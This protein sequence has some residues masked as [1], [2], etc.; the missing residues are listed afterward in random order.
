MLYETPARYI[1]SGVSCLAILVYD[2]GQVSQGLEM[3]IQKKCIT[4]VV[5]VFSGIVLALTVSAH[6]NAVD[7]V[8]IG[9]AG[10]GL[11]TMKLLG[12]A[13]EK[14]HPGFR[15]QV[16]PSL[17]SAGGI[18]ALAKKSLDIVTSSRPLR[19]EE[20]S[21]GL[22]EAAYARTPFVF[23]THAD[24]A[25]DGVTLGELEDIYIGKTV[26]WPG[27]TR[28]RL[29]L[30]PETDT[31]AGLLRSLS[32]VI[33]RA[34]K[35]AE[36]NKSKILAITDQ[37]CAETVAR[38]PG[39]FGALTLTQVVTEN[40]PLKILDF[41]GVTPSVAALSDGTYKLYK[42]LYLIT[43]ASSRP[44]VQ[45]FAEFVHSAEGR[46]IVAKSGN[47]A[48]VEPKRKIMESGK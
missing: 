45:R 13:F 5:S 8:R 10:A 24:V 18:T 36:S 47:L 28:I 37:N 16:F 12:E 38:A 31:D 4:R 9:G 25:K 29:V 42:T 11:G 21:S 23:V 33:E 15:V 3:K 43:G 26:T 6:A 44:A 19:P 46:R 2:P 27:G 17:G 7:V 34:L 1:R 22:V 20:R 35:I 48:I 30:R 32:P 14:K 40:R 39:A 41:N